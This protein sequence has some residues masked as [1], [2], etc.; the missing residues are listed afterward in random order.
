MTTKEFELSAYRN[1]MEEKVQSQLQTIREQGKQFTH[2]T[3]EYQLP[4]IE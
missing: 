2:K 1:L 4:I 3:T